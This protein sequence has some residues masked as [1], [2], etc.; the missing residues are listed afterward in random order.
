MGK[1][2]SG[3]KHKD[4]DKKR[5]RRSPLAIDGKLL[6]YVVAGRANKLA[7]ALRGVDEGAVDDV[8]ARGQSLMHKASMWLCSTEAQVLVP[9]QRPCRQTARGGNGCDTITAKR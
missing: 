3:K 6:K 8:D 5:E 2:K 4:K 9:V 1:S 7:R